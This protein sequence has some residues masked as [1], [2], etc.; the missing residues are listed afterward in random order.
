MGKVR[1]RGKKWYI[2]YIDASGKRIRK[3][4]G[5]TKKQAERILAELESRKYYEKENIPV[6]D[7][8][9]VEELWERFISMKKK[10]VRPR[11]METWK[12][13]LNFWKEKHLQKSKNF[14]LLPRLIIDKIIDELAE[15]Y[16]AKTVNDYINVLQQIYRYAKDLNL[17]QQNPA[18]KIKRLKESSKKPPRFLSKE[19]VNKI[20]EHSNDFYKSLF[21]F[22]LYTGMRRDEVRF[23]EWSETDFKNKIIRLGNKENFTTKSG[24]NRNIPMHSIVKKILEK[25][26]QNTTL[27]FESPEGGEFGRGTWRTVLLQA[28][29]RAGVENIT[30]HTFRHT[31]ASWLVMEAVD[32][33]TVAQ[34]L[35]H[36]DIKTTMKYAHLAPE[37]VKRAVDRLPVSF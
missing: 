15:K 2:D 17:L 35:G 33:P 22:F 21:Q 27:V 28:A 19:E 37:H 25:R 24:K 4:E 36:S 9:S 7:K 16:E 29:K 3:V 1:K 11:T 10:R 14:S 6:L 34:L 18:E 31:F 12:P 5:D 20:L 8:I 30:L 32:I 26:P 13:R 23:L